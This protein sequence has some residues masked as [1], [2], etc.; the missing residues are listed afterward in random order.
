M[1]DGGGIGDS[2][3]PIYQL[4]IMRAKELKPDYIIMIV[5]SR[6]MKGGKGLADGADVKFTIQIV[7]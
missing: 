4:F 7:L 3:K 6:W 1:I 2:A 5:P